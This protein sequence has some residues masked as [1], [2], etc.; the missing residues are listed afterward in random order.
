MFFDCPYLFFWKSSDLDQVLLT[1]DKVHFNQL[2]YIGKPVN[3]ELKLALDELPIGLQCSC[4]HFCTEREIQGGTIDKTDTNSDGDGYLRLEDMF[5]KCQ[6]E[7][8]VG[9]LLRVLEY[10]VA[11]AHSY[12][13]YM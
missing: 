3:A 11:C 9:L 10:T 12:T 6:K 7:K 8:A 2:R 13:T 5:E 4:F 1:G